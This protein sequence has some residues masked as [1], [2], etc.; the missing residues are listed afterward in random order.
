M[1]IT[2]ASVYEVVARNVDDLIHKG[3]V[4]SATGTTIDSTTLIHPLSG[5][6]KGY[7]CYIYEGG[8]SGQYKKIIDFTPASKRL[9]IDPAFTTVPSTNAKFLIF[10]K[11]GVEDYENALNRAMGAAKLKHLDEMSGTLG[12]VGSQYEYNVPSGMEFINTIRLVPSGGSDYSGDDE[13][14]RLF[15]LAP[16]YWRIE[17]NYGGTYQIIFDSRQINMDTI[18]GELVKVMGQ[19]KP[20]LSSATLPEDLQ[21]YLIAYSSMLLAGRKI[22]EGAE[23]GNKYNVFKAMV[24]E[25]EPY[26]HTPRRGKKVG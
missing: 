14:N 2:T 5:Q 21:E 6:L 9:T 26:I 16:H 17:K 22:S 24:G 1:A 25:L 12:I 20:D 18:D 19:S 10:K 15:E 7:E 11:F 8:G 23:W 4:A 13:V 3:T